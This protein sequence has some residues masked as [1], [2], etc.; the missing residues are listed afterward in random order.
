MSVQEP[1][2]LDAALKIAQRV[3]RDMGGIGDRQGTLSVVEVA[4][5]QELDSQQVRFSQDRRS[6]SPYQD[7]STERRR[8][9]YVPFGRRDDERR[10]RSPSPYRGSFPYRGTS[11]DRGFQNQEGFYPR[12]P[13]SQP[14]PTFEGN[15]QPRDSQGSYNDPRRQRHSGPRI[16]TH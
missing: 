16:I 7:R 12:R 14:R 11:P 2:T 4:T 5:P 13:I 1:E 6:P 3:E 9:E 15:R 10:N 8:Q